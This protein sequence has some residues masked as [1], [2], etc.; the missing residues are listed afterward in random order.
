MSASAA[1]VVIVGGGIAGASAAS[2]L[3]RRG[4]QV[5]V[6]E[7]QFEFRDRV[8]GETTQPWG[9][10]EMRRL[11]LEDVLVAA[12]GGY[13][14]QMVPYD[15]LRTPAEAEA[16]A[17]P[18]GM[19][20]GGVPGAFNVGHPQACTALLDHAEACGATVV[21]G[22]GD[23][24]VTPRASTSSSGPTIRYEHHG[25]MV[26]LSTR[27]VIGADGRQSTIRRQI[28]I[29]LQHAESTATLGGMLVRDE[30]WP[31]G[32]EVL[33][34]EGDVHFLMFPRPDG[35]VRLYLALDRNAAVGG[36]D[37]GERF[38]ESFRLECCPPAASLPHA[39]VLGPCAFYV[40]TDSWHDS[41]MVDGV[42]LIG[43]AAGWSDPIIGQGT[44]VA[45]RDARLVTDALLGDDWSPA[46]FE[47]YAIER[48]E[49]MRR[50]RMSGQLATKLRCTFTPEGRH[51][52]GVIF[53]QMFT[54]P[55]LL[56]AML[57]TL[58]GPDTAPD[59]SFT[60]EG[61]QRLMAIA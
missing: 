55:E 6:L 11:G 12:G 5:V 26:E 36:A 25:N 14:A 48:T 44:S 34:T 23:V 4:L 9:V 60:D 43:D 37:R 1:D 29:E 42:V 18:L 52:R 17:L 27:L 20:I 46:A 28:G 31:A 54:D 35:I 56:G 41:P 30:S 40:G 10:V 49:R 15:E 33:G 59:E 13:A 8:R 57:A 50:L 3:A 58:S 22:V 47:P 45:L 21:R 19:L 16:G 38:L 2:V 53:E 39:E 7:R 51:R 32:M 24:D 61:F